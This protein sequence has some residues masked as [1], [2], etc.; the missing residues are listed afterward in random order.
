MH[1][2]VR[3]FLLLVLLLS[4]GIVGCEF[5]SDADHVYDAMA[6]ISSCNEISNL[7]TI[8]TNPQQ[9]QEFVDAMTEYSNKLNQV[10]V[11]KCPA[12]FRESFKT[13]AA[14]VA[15][16]S[17]IFNKLMQGDPAAIFEFEAKGDQYVQDMLN[18]E[19]ALYQLAKD[20]YHVPIEE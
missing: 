8:P 3:Y 6:T 2:S 17:D 11:S 7:D 15:K 4:T 19:N 5:K 9:L 13:Y 1:T 18:S 10:D 12:D 20:K 16:C 14:N